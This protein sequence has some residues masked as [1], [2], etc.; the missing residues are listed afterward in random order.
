MNYVQNLQV[1]Y[2]K[3][4]ELYGDNDF[5]VSTTEIKQTCEPTFNGIT[6]LRKIII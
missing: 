4:V 1:L 3:V 2:D 6:F 5:C